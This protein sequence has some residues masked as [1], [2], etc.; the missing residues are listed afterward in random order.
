MNPDGQIYDTATGR[1]LS[2]VDK[3]RFVIGRIS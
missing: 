1:I 3:S 2:N